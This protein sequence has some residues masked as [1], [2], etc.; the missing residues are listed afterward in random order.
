[1]QAEGK[2]SQVMMMQVEKLLIQNNS[3]EWQTKARDTCI[4]FH[5]STLCGA[6]LIKMLQWLDLN[7]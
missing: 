2:A 1:L 4:S 3:V 5:Q 7:T 6:K